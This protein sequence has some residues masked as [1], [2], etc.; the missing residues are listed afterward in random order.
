MYM[1]DM[2]PELMGLGVSD[3]SCGASVVGLIGINRPFQKQVCL[4]FW[5]SATVNCWRTAAL[6]VVVRNAKST[7]RQPQANMFHS[8]LGFELCPRRAGAQWHAGFRNPEWLPLSPS[9]SI[10]GSGDHYEARGKSSTNER[11]CVYGMSRE[12]VL[13]RVLGRV[14][15]GSRSPFIAI[16][17]TS[18]LAFGLITFVGA[19]LGG[20]TALLLLGVFAIVIVAVLVLR[21]DKADH[22]HFKT[23]TP[24]A[25]LGALSCA[26]LVGPWTGRDAEQYAIAGILLAIGVLLW[27]VTAMVMHSRGK[28]SN[29]DPCHFVS[30]ISDSRLRSSRRR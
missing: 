14:H 20:T 1:S 18:I 22:E 10:V 23:P 2:S 9:T 21:K 12:G 6:V 24:V 8:S 29:T 28:F 15:P 5:R 25:V 17:F 7:I 19:A 26:F 30:V 16:A 4:G 3:G 27:C 13:P 11:F